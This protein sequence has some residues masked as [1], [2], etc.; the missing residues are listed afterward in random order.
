MLLDDVKSHVNGQLKFHYEVATTKLR[1]DLTLYLSS[2]KNIVWCELTPLIIAISMFPLLMSQN[3]VDT[4]NY[5]L[6]P[7]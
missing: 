1:H 2:I 6:I 3:L 4:P 7:S 5:R